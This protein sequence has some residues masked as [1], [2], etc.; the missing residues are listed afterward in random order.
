MSGVLSQ[1]MRS[2]R[3]SLL[4]TPASSRRFTDFVTNPA[5]KTQVYFSESLDPYRNLSIEH[6]LLQKTPADSTVLFFYVNRPCIVIG[7]NQ[8]PWVEV[9]LPLLEQV[10]RQSHNPSPNSSILVRTDEE[11]SQSPGVELVRRRSGGGAVFHDSGNVNFS[12][13]CPS[14]NFDRDRH[15]EMVVRALKRLGV[16]GAMVN[17]RHDIIVADD[18]QTLEKVDNG[19]CKAGQTGTFKVSGSAYKLTRLRSLHHGTCLLASPNLK[20]I[21]QFLRSPARGFIDAR[22]VES[23]R[24]PVKNVGIP[25]VKA[26]MDTVLDEFSKMYGG[27]K[28]FKSDK[29]VPEDWTSIEKGIKELK[30]RDWIYGQTPRFTVSSSLSPECAALAQ[31]ELGDNSISFDVAHGGFDSLVLNGRTYKFAHT[32]IYDL[33]NWPEFLS[34]LGM[35]SSKAETVGSWVGKVLGN[36][37]TSLDV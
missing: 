8:N 3:K 37:W 30:S 7:R 9:N 20:N 14:A 16:A 17:C 36:S 11:M 19:T 25:S 27:Y 35:D 4:V 1:S 2:I 28:V 33:K 22:G 12:V 31:A 29:T 21:S 34:G 26:F 6:E 10:R 23:V 13:L 18:P 32:N 24:S 15:A 5:N